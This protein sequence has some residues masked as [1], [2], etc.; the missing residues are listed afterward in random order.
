MISCI[1]CHYGRT[2]LLAEAIESYIQQ[3][4]S[5]QSE[6]IIINDHPEITLRVDTSRLSEGQEIRV[7]NW[8]KR[9]AT[10]SH[11]F[12][13]GATLA[14]GELIV[15]WD[16][17][18]LSLPNRLMYQSAAWHVAGKPAYL[19][20]DRHFY[21]DQHG[22][23]LV[24]RGVHGGDIMTREGYWKAGGSVGEGHN[25]Q[26]IV[27]EFKRQGVYQTHNDS[28]P[29]Y[30]YRWA[31]VGSHHSSHIALDTAMDTFDKRVRSHPSF[32][33]GSVTVVPSYTKK[34]ETLIEACKADMR[35]EA[36]RILAP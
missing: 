32:V 23:H 12:D 27:A 8:G 6:L 17:D 31:G 25:D 15:M 11:K 3:N 26:N 29:T 13:Y 33:T 9:M 16:D 35:R 10:L 34:T 22:Q 19:S 21:I 30:L 7:I 24:A 2:W 5:G 14:R 1:C 20:F 18:D 28:L 36:R 4:Y